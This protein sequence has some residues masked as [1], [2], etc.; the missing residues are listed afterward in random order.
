[1]IT[2]VHNYIGEDNIIRKGAISALAGQKLLI[3]WNMRDGLLVGL[4]KGNAEWNN[5]APHGSGRRMAR[6]QAKRELSVNDFKADMEGIWSS[7]V[8]KETLDESPA[9]YKPTKNVLGA[10]GDTVDVVAQLKPV[11]N[12]KAG[13]E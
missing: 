3:P 1:M 9:A 13:K 4:G 5:S 6:G 12:F 8:G 10:I 11:Y 7:C 2:S